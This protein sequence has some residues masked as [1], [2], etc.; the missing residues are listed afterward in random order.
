MK[1]KFSFDDYLP[2]E[3][4]LE[5]HDTIIFIRFVFN[6]GNKYFLYVFLDDCLYKLAE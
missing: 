5:I 4:T 2:L 3:R 6:Y 1:I